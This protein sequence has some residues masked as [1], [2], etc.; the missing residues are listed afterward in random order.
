MNNPGNPSFDYIYKTLSDYLGQLLNAEE[1]PLITLTHSNICTQILHT[2]VPVSGVYLIVDS[3]TKKRLYIGRSKDLA[4]RVGLNHR[5][6]KRSQ[7]TLAY[8]IMMKEKLHDLDDARR[9]MFERCSVK[10]ISLP[11]VNVRAVFEIFASLELN[12]VYNTFEEH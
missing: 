12:T 7:A 2:K 3:K 11:D 6:N 4:R 9:Y 5:S 10:M 1:Y 8:R